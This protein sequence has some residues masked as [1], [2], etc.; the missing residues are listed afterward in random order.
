M[1]AKKL[2]SLGIAAA[3]LVRFFLDPGRTGAAEC[4]AGGSGTRGMD[5]D[6]EAL[7]RRCHHGQ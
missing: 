2:A 6:L 1:H 4:T 7:H 5:R 3:G